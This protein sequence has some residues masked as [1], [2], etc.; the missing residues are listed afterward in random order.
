MRVK[1][2]SWSVRSC[3][4][5]YLNGKS[6]WCQIGRTDAAAVCFDHPP[7]NRQPEPVTARFPRCGPSEEGFENRLELGGRHARPLR[8]HHDVDLGPYAVTPGCYMNAR[9]G[10]RV[11]CCVTCHI[12]ERAMQRL[13]VALDADS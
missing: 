5:A 8:P 12:F 10:R 6:T 1:S 13:G 2:C 4:Q 7:C 3:W 9:A 11:L